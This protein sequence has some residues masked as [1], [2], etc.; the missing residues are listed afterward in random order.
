MLHAARW[1]CRTQKIAK[2]SPSGHHRTNLSGYI[3]ATVGIKLVKQQYLHHMSLQYGELRPVS[4]DLGCPSSTQ[5]GLLRPREDSSK[6]ELKQSF[7]TLVTRSTPILGNVLTAT[8]YFAAK[9]L[10][11]GGVHILYNSQQAGR[12]VGSL[13]CALYGGGVVSANVI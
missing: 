5:T 1:K 12:G 11:L 2:N 13:L 9:P 7:I 4:Y 8:D 3:L 10:Q 6:V